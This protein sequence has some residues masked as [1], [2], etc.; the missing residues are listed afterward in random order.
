MMIS[1]LELKFFFQVLTLLPENTTDW[2]WDSHSFLDY[3][4]YFAGGILGDSH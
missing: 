4:T 1:E 2:F 3:I